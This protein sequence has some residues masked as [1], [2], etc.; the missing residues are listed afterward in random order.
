LCETDPEKAEEKDLPMKGK[1]ERRL[2]YIT[3]KLC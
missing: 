2:Q 3:H 1:K